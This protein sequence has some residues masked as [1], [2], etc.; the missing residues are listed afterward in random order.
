MPNKAYT[1]GRSAEYYVIGKLKRLGADPIFRTAGSHGVADIIAVF[2]RINE[3]WLVQV[4]TSKH[5]IKLK[6]LMKEYP[7]MPNID[8]VY[9]VRTGFFFKDK[10]GWKETIGTTLIE[11]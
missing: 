6:Q 3:I 7:N 1:M 10:E 8:G 9:T 11:A 4:K 5:G 2:Q